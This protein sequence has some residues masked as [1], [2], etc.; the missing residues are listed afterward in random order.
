MFLNTKPSKFL[1]CLSKK[2]SNALAIGREI[3][4]CNNSI[5]DNLNYFE[6]RGLITVDKL[7][8]ELKIKLTQKGNDYIDA[9]LVLQS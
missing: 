6:D 3:Y 9:I 7:G 1:L 4:S 5:Y 8:R 2:H